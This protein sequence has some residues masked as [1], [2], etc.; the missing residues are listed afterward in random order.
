MTHLSTVLNNKLTRE[1]ERVSRAPGKP[2]VLLHALAQTLPL[3][4][5]LICRV[6]L[7]WLLLIINHFSSSDTLPIRFKF[8]NFFP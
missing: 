1:A 5:Q 6:S 4:L 3:S 7:Y 8:V 2:G